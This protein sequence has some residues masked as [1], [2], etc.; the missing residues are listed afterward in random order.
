MTSSAQEVFGH[1]LDAKDCGDYTWKWDRSC[2]ALKK[3]PAGTS[4]WAEILHSTNA[5]HPT[6][7]V[8][9]IHLCAHS[10]CTAVWPASKYGMT[11]PPLH[12][13]AG[14]KPMPS[15]VAELASEETTP[16]A[17]GDPAEE[18]LTPAE[19]QLALAEVEAAVDTDIVVEMV[20]AARDGTHPRLARQG[21]RQ[22]GVD[23]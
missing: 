2:S 21:V 22:A 18:Q 8:C 3:N 16:Q 7:T 17:G 12:L 11:G 14:H 15:A 4:G 9:R 6:G 5:A 13:Q 1:S 23:P 10:P 19:Q 20:V